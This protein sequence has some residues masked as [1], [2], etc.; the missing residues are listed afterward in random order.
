M[1]FEMFEIGDWYLGIVLETPFQWI[2]FVLWYLG[3]IIGVS[4]LAE[5]LTH[6]FSKKDKNIMSI[7][8]E[9]NG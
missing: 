8:K 9:A 7:E 5:K 3:I 2:T 1:C 6:K 4:R